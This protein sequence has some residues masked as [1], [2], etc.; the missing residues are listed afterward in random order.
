MTAHHKNKPGNTNAAKTKIPEYE[1][2][3]Y[4]EVSIDD[5]I[6][7]DTEKKHLEKAIHDKIRT[8]DLQQ[9]L[10][11]I[12]ASLDDRHNPNTHA[13]KSIHNVEKFLYKKVMQHFKG[14]EVWSRVNLWDVAN[15]YLRYETQKKKGKYSSIARGAIEDITL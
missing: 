2:V 6:F 5:G 13:E 3:A 11:R 8:C 15:F 9:F 7:S 14:W 4:I 1:T 12:I 10:V